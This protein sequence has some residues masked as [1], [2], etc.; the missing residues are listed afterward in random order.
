MTQNEPHRRRVTLRRTR[1]RHDVLNAVEA[2]ALERAAM[3][4]EIA[5]QLNTWTW[6]RIA[7]YVLVI[8]GA[9]VIINHTFMHLGL[10]W[11][12]MSQGRQDVVAGWPLGGVLAMVGFVIGG[13][14]PS[15]AKKDRPHR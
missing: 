1:R 13:Q 7:A 4:R 14:T 10:D 15:A 3:K 9:L 11:L 5:R 8:V 2:A 12:P 6:R